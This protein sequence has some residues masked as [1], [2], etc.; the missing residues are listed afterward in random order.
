MNL[1]TKLFPGLKAQTV[2]QREQRLAYKLLV[3]SLLIL[4][5]IAAYPLCNVVYSSFTNAKFASSQKTEFVGFENYK[6]LLSVTVKKLESPD[7]RARKV[8]PREPIRYKEL[9]RF[10]IGDNWYIVGAS[11]REFLYSVGNTLVFTF[12]SVFLELLIG[13]GIALVVNSNFKGKGPM[14][15]VMLIPW[16]VITVVSARIWEWMFRSNRTGL[17]NMIMD[18][19]GLSD[20]QLSFL[21]TPS[22]QMPAMI[23]VDVWKTAPFMALLLLAG[24]QTIPGPLYEAARV[25]GATKTK[26]FFAIT[27]PLLKPTIAVALIFRTLDSLRVFDVFQVMLADRRYSMATYNYTQ[28]IKFQDMGM[29][30]AIGVIIFILIFGFA[31]SYMKILKVES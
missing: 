12:W 30:S 10:N 9:T 6:K 19:T 13:M 1:L 8:L 24:L 15:A 23:A 29:A 26:Q 5:I 11:D 22:L 21:T 14:R 3:P 31:L 25:D 20:G 28:L 27:L 18:A 2:A 4:I 7:Q 17:F 16:A